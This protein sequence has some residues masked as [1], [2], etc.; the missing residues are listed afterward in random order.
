MGLSPRRGRAV[1]IIV[2]VSTE[3]RRSAAGDEQLA[4]CGRDRGAPA[5]ERR[6]GAARQARRDQARARRPRL[7][8]PR[9]VRGRAGHRQDRARPRDRAQRRGHRLRAHPVHARP[10]A[11][12][13]DRRE[14]LRPEAP[15]LRV[16]PRA[17]VR[18]RRARRRDQPRDAED[19]VGAARGDGR[20]PGD[21]RRADVRAPAAV[22][23]ARDREP[24]RVRGRLPAPRGPAR[25]LLPEGA[26]RLPG[27]GGRARASSSTSR[28][29]I[30]ST[31]S[32]RW[33]S[34][35]ELDRLEASLGAVYVDD[36]VRRWTIKL[37]RA[38]R[39]LP[40][41][42]I[43]ASVRGSL[44]LERASR[45]WALLDGRAYTT[46]DDVERMFAPVLGHRLVFSPSFIAES[47]GRSRDEILERGLRTL[48]RGGA[49]ARARRTRSG[50]R[51]GRR[52]AELP[53][54][55][56]LAARRLGL[57]APARRAARDRVERRHHA[58]SYRPGD[59]PGMID[60]KLSARL[61]SIRGTAE[62]I[63]REDFA[64]EAP[65]A[66]VVA[67]R[68]PSMCLY[69]DD[70]PWLSK[71]AALRTVWQ[72]VAAASVQEL[73]LAGY[74]D[75][76]AGDGWFAPRPTARFAEIDA[77]TGA[78]AFDAD[79][80]RARGGASSTWP[81]AAARCRPARSCSSARTSSRRPSPTTWL[82][83]LGASLG[84]RPRG[85]AG[86]GL[87]AEL[88]AG[89]RP[90]RPVRRPRDRPRSGRCGSRPRR[91]GGCASCT[92]PGSPGCSR[93]SAASASTTSSSATPT[94]L[95]S[96]RAFVDWAEARIAYRR[97]A[98]R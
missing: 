38:T 22:P 78:A 70:L 19:P 76:A 33:S 57:R 95:P 17:A 32:S 3:R 1:A 54:R 23:R 81:A 43:G 5:R 79:P 88:P 21:D 44:A 41:V 93:S 63:V 39:E 12:G 30:R 69:P 68:A 66:V 13:R 37:V 49:A 60:W 96:Y 42:S 40:E 87:G 4:G 51:G 34:V 67:D 61:S 56:A 27:R 62:F 52:R 11:V 35:A 84:P 29:A 53:A 48:R 71:P 55:P 58:R 92:R 9:A 10:P 59:D 16:P 77:R 24:D 73:G 47:R 80:A 45:A 75:T 18:E 36:L 50:P 46:P 64:D 91:H 98:W 25:P 97:G 89:R 65:R 6:A 14:H 72:A 82:R 26:A 90:R 31:G 83:A 28:R 86:P 8:R 20:A 15:R 2:A 85:R 94:R 7:P 74:L